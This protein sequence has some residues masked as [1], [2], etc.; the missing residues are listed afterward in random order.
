MATMVPSLIPDWHISPPAIAAARDGS[1]LAIVKLDGTAFTS[2]PTVTP[3]ASGSL[4]A[5]PDE[6]A[7]KLVT[8]AGTTFDGDTFS[9]MFDGNSNQVVYIVP[10]EQ[11]VIL[12]VGDAP[13]RSAAQEWDNSMLP[14]TILRGIR[15]KAGDPLPV[16]QPG[17]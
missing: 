12:R 15:R 2:G 3:P 14:N 16:P 5:N 8:L 17:G 6:A 4:R 13:P 11:L 9:F 1:S 7:V 10:S